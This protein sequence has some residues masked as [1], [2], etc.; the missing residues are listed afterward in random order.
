M[1][2]QMQLE[3]DGK[4]QNQTKRVEVVVKRREVGSE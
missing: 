1:N 3:M 4:T 2:I